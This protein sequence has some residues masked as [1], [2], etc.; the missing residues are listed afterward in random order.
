MKINK[1]YGLA[2]G[3]VVY[4][5]PKQSTQVKIN[6]VEFDENNVEIN[7]IEDISHF[8]IHTNNKSKVQWYNIIGLHNYEVISAIGKAYDMHPIALENVVDVFQRPIF[9]EYD[10]SIFFSLKHMSIVNGEVVRK[11]VSLYFG[12]GYV[13][14]FQEAGDDIFEIIRNRINVSAARIRGRKSDYLAYSILDLII[15][16]YFVII[17][18]FEQ[19]IEE[20][21]EM[22]SENPEVFDK[23]QI[24]S[25][26]KELMKV[27]KSI[28]PLREA[29]NQFNRTE[30]SFVDERTSIFIK[31]LYD[32]TIQVMDHID[33]QREMLS[34]LQDLYISE[35]S[36]K[37]NRIMQFLTVVTA[38]FVPLS[39]L[40]GLY[41]MNFE[42]I[43]ELKIQN[44]YFLL[45][46]FMLFIVLGMLIWMKRKKWL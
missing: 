46:A 11:S 3:T 26:K 31:D 34:S 5:G 37:M 41:G 16:Q 2:P 43:P 9:I 42:Y 22:I 1:N 45:W 44:G 27:R 6:Y 29:I 15:D 17:E 21:E 38:I 4:N 40:T 28:T 18:H 10:D 32:H 20:S 14:S 19:S 36:L 7:D 23:G 35:V 39:F 8:N 24:F 12:E 13:L 30:A 25:V 33:G